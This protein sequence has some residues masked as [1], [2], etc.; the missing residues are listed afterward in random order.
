MS[1]ATG[2]R[3]AMEDDTYGH[4]VC[5][6]ALEGLLLLPQLSN[7]LEHPLDL[8]TSPEKRT[9]AQGSAWECGRQRTHM[10]LARKLT[11][12]VLDVAVHPSFDP[13][14]TRHRAQTSSATVAYHEPS[15]SNPSCTH[16]SSTFPSATNAGSIP[17]AFS[18]LTWSAI[19]ANT[20]SCAACL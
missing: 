9:S 8:R 19:C 15:G 3:R 10:Y 4:Q 12:E 18:A 20:A 6:L 5:D 2:T 17:F 16:S 1:A 13:P 11:P 14:A 7:L